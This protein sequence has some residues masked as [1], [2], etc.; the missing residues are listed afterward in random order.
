[1]VSTFVVLYSAL[2]L[3]IAIGMTAW[4]LT[5]AEGKVGGQVDGMLGVCLLASGTLFVAAVIPGAQLP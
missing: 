4:R 5:S 1:M 3:A 2:M